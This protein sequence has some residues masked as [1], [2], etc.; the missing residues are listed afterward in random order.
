L[1]YIIRIV[2]STRNSKEY[3]IEMGK[4]IQY[5]ASPRASIGLYIASKANAFM[6]GSSFVTPQHIKE[7][8]YPILRHR[9]ILNY[10]G[11]ADDIKTDNIIK[12]IL[13]KVPIP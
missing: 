10:E 11:L 5:G 2:D 8:A 1:K 7:I 4:Y 3:N 12:E 6:Q 13:S 9:I